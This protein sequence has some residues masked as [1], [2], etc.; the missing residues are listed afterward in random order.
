MTAAE[1]NMGK[2]PVAMLAGVLQRAR[3]GLQAWQGIIPKGVGSEIFT[4][5][6]CTGIEPTGLTKEVMWKLEMSG[7]AIAIYN[8]GTS[9]DVFSAVLQ[10]LVESEE[11]GVQWTTT[12]L[13]IYKSKDAPV[14]WRVRVTVMQELFLDGIRLLMGTSHVH[15]KP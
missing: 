12:H 2:G 14:A 13:D 3:C 8:T 4:A 10:C 9:A 7:T 15:A 11:I 5:A 1:D 6:S